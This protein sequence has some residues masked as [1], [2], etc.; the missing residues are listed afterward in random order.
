M[1]SMMEMPM[2]ATGQG[3]FEQILMASSGVV[4]VRSEDG[5]A[6]LEQFRVIA[7][8]NGQAVYCWQPGLGLSSLRD[9]H[10]RIPEA[11]RLGQALRY[12]Q[13]SM[14]FGVY[15]LQELDAPLAPSDCA[16]LR[17]LARTP[18]AHPRRVVLLNAPRE[19][20]EQLGDAV[21][22]IEGDAAFPGRLRLR[23]GRWLGG[24]A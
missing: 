1:T 24:R 22:S 23:D 8:H 7:K 10:A 6:L 20:V 21:V 19:L 15:V 12:M 3:V 2:P 18:T 5:A 9:A 14:H 13:Q 16:Q 4:A 17:Q 11:Q